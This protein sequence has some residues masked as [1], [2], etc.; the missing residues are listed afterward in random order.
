METIMMDGA[1]IEERVLDKQERRKYNPY[2]FSGKSFSFDFN[3]ERVILDGLRNWE[4]SFFNK[5][6]WIFTKMSKLLKGLKDDPK[7][8][9]S[10]EFDVLVKILKI[11]EKDDYNWEMR[12]KDLSN[13]MWF[14]VVPKLKFGALREGEVIRIR[15]VN[16]NVTSKRNVLQTKN[17]TNIL[18]FTHKSAIVRQLRNK[19]EDETAADLMMLEESANEVIMSPVAYTTITDPDLAKA[20]LFKLDD[21][22]L[23]YDEIPADQKKLNKFRV[24]FYA[25]RIDPQDPKEVVQALDPE[26]KETFSC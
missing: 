26:T 20:P 17:S 10:R 18:R 11:F 3:Q 2:K 21:L 5:S 14:I 16:V 13:E 15:S 7:F 22:F 4:D 19:V 1:D 8:D 25:L 9:G 24:R 6:S 12:I 23:R